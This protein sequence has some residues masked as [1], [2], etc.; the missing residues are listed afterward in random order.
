MQPEAHHLFVTG[1]TPTNRF[2]R[3]GILE[4]ILGIIEIGDGHEFGALGQQELFFEEVG[5][6]PAKIIVR[7]VEQHFFV[8][9]RI[10]GLGQHIFAAEMHVGGVGK[11]NHIFRQDEA[12]SHAVVVVV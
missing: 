8:A 5:F 11:R 4:I 9:V 1:F 3:I 7:N 10:D 12:G 2:G 6:L